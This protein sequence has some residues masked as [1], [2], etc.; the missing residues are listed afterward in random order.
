MR[1]V[2]NYRPN[3]IEFTASSNDVPSS[4]G[5]FE[6]VDEAQKF[7]SDNFVALSTKFTAIRKI[8]DHEIDELRGEYIEELEAEL[9]RHQENLYK[10]EI[11]LAD[12]KDKEKIAKETV[13]ASLNKIQALSKEV[14][15]GVT[16]MNLDQAYTYEVAYNGKRYYYTIM[17]GNI[18]LAGVRTVGEHELEDLLSSSERNADSFI[19]LK[20]AANQ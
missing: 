1:K 9:P 15:E 12:I 4:L 7:M 17:D 5:E 3:E 11:E 14:R 16:E 13:N 2:E 8:D 10:I 18:Q 6:S 20:R 19:Q